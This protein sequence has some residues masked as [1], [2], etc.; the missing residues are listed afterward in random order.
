MSDDCFASGKDQPIVETR[1]APTITLP[2]ELVERVVRE[3]FSILPEME[4]LNWRIP[5]LTQA[6]EA[7]QFEIAGPTNE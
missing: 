6:M 5:E 4:S 7:L 2:L 3:F 1:N